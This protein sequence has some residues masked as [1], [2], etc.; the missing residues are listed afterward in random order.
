MQKH[1]A[2]TTQIMRKK[3]T[4][5]YSTQKLKTSFEKDTKVGRMVPDQKKVVEIFKS[6]KGLIAIEYNKVL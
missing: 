6:D 4:D 2:S 3:L 1:K 5:I